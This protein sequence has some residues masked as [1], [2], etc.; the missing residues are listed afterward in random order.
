MKERKIDLGAGSEQE[1]GGKLAAALEELPAGEALQFATAG[2]PRGIVGQL[3]NKYWGSFDWAPLEEGEG[4][5]LSRINK[6]EQAGPGTIL[7][8]FASDHR[9]C[10]GLFA[11]AE[12]AAHEGD[13]EKA[14]RLFG[15]YE[16]GMERHFKREEEGFFAEFDQRMGF[17]GGGPTAVMREEHRQI[18]GLLERMRG[19]LDKPD[20]EEFAAACET[21]LYLMEQHNMKEEQMLYPMTANAFG[22]EVEELL[23][24]LYLI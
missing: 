15:W 17:A 14:A 16:L 11:D 9:R 8:M 2:D 24:R 13:G 10:D 3:I 12:A 18:R 5:Y 21:M 1:A 23:K 20:L 22:P 6:L 7:E 19:A 4:G